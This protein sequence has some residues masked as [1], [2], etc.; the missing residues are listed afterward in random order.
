MA[1]KKIKKQHPADQEGVNALPERMT[2]PAIALSGILVF[3]YALTPLVIDGEESIELVQKVERDIAR[4]GS[5]LDKCRILCFFR[6]YRYDSFY[7]VGTGTVVRLNSALPSHNKTIV[8]EFDMSVFSA[9]Y[10]AKHCDIGIVVPRTAQL[11]GLSV[12][13]TC[14]TTTSSFSQS[15]T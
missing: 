8:V 6:S 15:I 12:P 13:L 11:Q 2:V 1:E 7:I 14:F 5:L 4:S 3:P 9:S 10:Q